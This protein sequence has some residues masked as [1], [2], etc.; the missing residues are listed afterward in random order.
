MAR[1]VALRTSAIFVLLATAFALIGNAS[2]AP[3]AQALF[4]ISAAVCGLTLLLAS[5][6]PTPAPIPIPVR[7]R[8]RR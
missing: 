7:A 5:A 3:L 6:S 1:S 4:L 2:G 8:R